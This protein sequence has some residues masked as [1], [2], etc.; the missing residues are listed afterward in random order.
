[1]QPNPFDDPQQDCLVLI[2]AYQQY[3][4]WPA[5]R[6][7]PAGWRSVFGPRP[8]AE[9]LNWLNANWRDIRPAHPTANRSDHV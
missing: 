3:S 7:L 8:Q 1:M 2:N 6:A 4:L 9:C 5:F